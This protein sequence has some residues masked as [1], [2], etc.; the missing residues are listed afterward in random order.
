MQTCSEK[1]HGGGEEGRRVFVE[2]QN[3]VVLWVFFLIF[4]FNKGILVILHSKPT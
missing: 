1:E 2:E 3:D 4:N